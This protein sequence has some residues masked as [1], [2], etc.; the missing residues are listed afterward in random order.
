MTISSTR[1]RFPLSSR[2]CN[3]FQ[4]PTQI[5]LENF[6]PY[7]SSCA[8]L[9]LSVSFLL[10]SSGLLC[11][12]PTI[13]AELQGIKPY[14]APTGIDSSKHLLP[15]SVDEHCCGRAVRLSK[16]RNLAMRT[17]VLDPGWASACS[18]VLLAHLLQIELQRCHEE[19]DCFV[20][21][22]SLGPPKP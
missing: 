14:K 9:R 19:S 6:G 22:I 10:P 8:P 18:V 16:H 5:V 3:R 2:I 20:P 7:T 12:L 15:G 1:N 13:L 17:E 11:F 21:D 4:I